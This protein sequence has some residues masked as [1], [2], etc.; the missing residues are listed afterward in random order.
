MKIKL[1]LLAAIVLLGTS[2]AYAQ[3]SVQIVSKTGTGVTVTAACIA[4]HNCLDVDL[5]NI[6]HVICDSGCSS[7]AGFA[8][9]ST[10]TVGTSAINPMGAYYTSGAAPSISTGNAGRVRMDANSYLFVDCVTG[11]AGGATTPA[12]AFTTPTTAG[13]SASFLMGYNG[14]SW[15]LLRTGDKNNVTGITGVLNAA[16]LGRYNATQPTLTDTRYNLFQLSQRGELFVAPGVSGF[17]VTLTSTTVTGTVAVT[18]STSPWIDSITTWGGGTLG[19]MAN[20]GT[21]PGAVLA[22]GVNAFI[23]NI[24]HAII[25]SGS[26]TAVTGNVTVVQPTGTSLH[27]VLDTTS[28]TAV[29]Q[30]T[31]TNLHAVIDSGS[32]T[33]VTGNVTVVQP[34]GTSLHAVLDTTST[35][36]VTQATA[37][38]LNA[39]VVG[40]GTFATQSTLAAETTKVI[41]TVNQGTSPWV[42]SNG[43]TFA[44]QGVDIASGPDAVNTSPTKN[45]LQIGGVDNTAN[46]SAAPCVQKAVFSN[47]Q[48]FGNEYALVT[49]DAADQTLLATLASI[50]VAQQNVRVRG[51][52]GIPL[53]SIGDALKVVPIQTD[54]CAGVKQSFPISQ[55]TGTRYVIGN[56]HRAY[57]CS[58]IVVGSDAENVSLVEGTG[59]VCA[60]G[61]IAVIGGAT[62][63]AGPN[64]AA[65]GGFT[66]G[67]GAGTIAAVGVSGDDVCLFESGSGRVAGVM[68]VAFG[69]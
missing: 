61:T 62:A 17:P 35:T 66:L 2:L 58:I 54:P 41:G 26:T 64:M 53:G 40:T 60:T 68:T 52:F 31:G 18:Q 11:C 21:S 69:Q 7:S 15:D 51:T 24:P 6:P 4:S 36:A 30:A 10:F 12:D 47:G 19:A 13:L 20:Y 16:P 56:G 28:T 5:L 27:A 50:L 29:T 25:D 14:A 9:N 38:N 43:G 59:T 65:N 57:I 8:D 37:G 55:T 22:P 49:R 45:P 23:T 3:G 34:T 32:T 42:V 63:A 67:N 46:C 44:V 48:L 1:L 33:A 39:T